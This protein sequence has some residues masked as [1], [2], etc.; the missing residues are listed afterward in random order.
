MSSLRRRLGSWANLAERRRTA[1]NSPP[2]K[3][4]D[5]FAKIG[6]TE[7]AGLRWVGGAKKWWIDDPSS[8]HLFGGRH[9]RIDRPHYRAIL[10]EV[11]PDVVVGDVTSLDLALP[12]A[13]RSAGELRAGT[14]LVLRRTSGS[15]DWATSQ[16]QLAPHERAVDETVD[17]VADVL[18]PDFLPAGT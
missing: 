3:L 17:S 8:M 11:R 18:H 9:V 14:R 6:V 4:G 5:L 7:G 13:M 15:P 2:E 16:P 1:S 12:A 10:E